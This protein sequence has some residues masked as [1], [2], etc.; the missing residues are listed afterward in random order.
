MWT[1]TTDLG[2]IRTA[3][4]PPELMPPA[5]PPPAGTAH[6]HP[7]PPGRTD[8][9]HAAAPGTPPASPEA[10]PGRGAARPHAPAALPPLPNPRVDGTA[11]RAR[12][13]ARIAGHQTPRRGLTGRDAARPPTAGSHP[14]P[15]AARPPRPPRS[16]RPGPPRTPAPGT[17]HRG[18][19]GSGSLPRKEVI[20]PQL[21][22]RLPC[23]DFVPVSSPALD[24][25]LPAAGLAR[26]LQALPPPMT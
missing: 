20:Q 13:N 25:C 26:R 19:S 22:L 15:T 1:R 21:P 3:L 23:Y 2:L 17:P 6:R 16:D 10:K 12:P 4:S 5:H 8:G 18:P 24:A 14:A 11:C 9:R 7:P